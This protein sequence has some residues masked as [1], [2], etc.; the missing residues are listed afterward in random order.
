MEALSGWGRVKRKT[1]E[2]QSAQIIGAGLP[3]H[4]ERFKQDEKGDG[5]GHWQALVE[6]HE[7]RRAGLLW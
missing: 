6:H 2:E 5:D 4:E 3:D 7:H 1:T